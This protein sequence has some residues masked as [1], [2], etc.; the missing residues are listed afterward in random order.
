MSN[1]HQVRKTQ[2][3]RVGKRKEKQKAHVSTRVRQK[4]CTGW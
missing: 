3:H 2:V 1:M 4:D